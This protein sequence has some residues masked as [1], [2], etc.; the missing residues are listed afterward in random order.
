MQR[1][2]QLIPT[3][4]R[5][6]LRNI[7]WEAHR[8][9]WSQLSRLD[10]ALGR[11][12]DMIPPKS[13]GFV[14]GG[15]PQT[16]GEEYL[17]YFQR[18]CG[19]QPHERVLDIG[20]GNGRMAAPLTRY[21]SARGSYE[22]FEIV[23]RGVAWCRGRITPRFTN[24]RF[25]LADVRNR[26]YNPTGSVG[27]DSYTF[28]FESGSFDFAFATSVFSHLMPCEATRYLSELARVLRSGGRA[29]LTFYLLNEVSIVAI[30][31]ERASPKFVH[32]CGRYRTISLTEPE[33]AIALH[34]SEMAAHCEAVG[35]RIRRPIEYGPWT[36]RA[37]L[38]WQDIVVVDRV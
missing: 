24:F 15:D 5:T 29:L 18:L 22:G 17:G 4:A 36:G 6:A 19:L 20:S 38:S 35:L 16:I 32:D 31:E 10:S 37:G 13:L 23:P 30:A 12:T 33:A 11:E 9:A 2:T 7:K 28:P 34:E 1:L 26:Y 3:P 27:A 25:Q 8:I 14:G 21:L